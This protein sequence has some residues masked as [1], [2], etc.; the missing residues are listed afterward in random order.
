M[1]IF[2]IVFGVFPYQF[3]GGRPSVLKYMQATIDQ[4]VA[5][6]SDW[7]RELD[8]AGRTATAQNQPTT[9]AQ[10]VNSLPTSDL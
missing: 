3:P 1:A 2:A 7:T 6:L 4:Q 5:D 8:A 10:P 9:P